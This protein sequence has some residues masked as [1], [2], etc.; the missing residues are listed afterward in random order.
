MDFR[1]DVGGIVKEKIK[2]VMAFVV[3]CAND[4][5][6]DR[7]IVGHHGVGDDAFFEPEVFGRIAGIDRVNGGL[8]LLAITAGVNRIADIIMFKHGECGDRIT[9]PIIGLPESLQTDKIVGCRR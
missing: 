8:K 7:D 4:I 1:L 2:D 9:D 6:I 5:G 3:V